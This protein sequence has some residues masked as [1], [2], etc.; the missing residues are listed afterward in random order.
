MIKHLLLLST[1]LLLC[2]NASAQFNYRFKDTTTAYAPLAGATSLNGSLI[3]DE[4]NLTAPMPFT[5]KID[6]VISV[7]K[8]NLALAFTAVFSD[9][10]NFTDVNGFAFGDMDI[11]DRGMLTNVSSQSPIRYL[12]TGTSPNRIFKVELANAGFYEEY[13]TYTSMSDSFNLQIWVYETSN[14]V[15]FHYGPS[16]ITHPSDYFNFGNGPLVMYAKHADYD[17]GSTGTVYLL[18]GAASAPTIDSVSLPSLPST[19]LNSWPA[20][21]KVYRFTPKS[22]CSAPTANLTAGTPSGKT[23]QYTYTGTTSNLDSLVWNFGDGT[24]QKVTTGFTAPISHT[25]ATNGQYTVSVTAYTSCGSN[26][27]TKQIKLAVGGIASMANV[28][29]YPNPASDHL[30]IEWMQSADQATVHSNVGQ[31]V[32]TCA[33]AGN[34]QTINIASLPAGTY[35]LQL[36]D[37]NGETGS[38]RFTKE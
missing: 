4:E 21:G 12:T 25:F 23:M 15:E 9:T 5:W 7:T 8:F 38:V 16:R 31:R 18:K 17:M 27:F 1:A 32:L 24:K 33:I 11:A 6:S 30:K 20:N 37:K 28:Q 14:I 29:V 3:W 13:N 10:T 26:I 36:S 34:V 22:V 35:I 2:L 19:A